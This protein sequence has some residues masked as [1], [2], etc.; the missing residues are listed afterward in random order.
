MIETELIRYGY[1]F[2]FLGTLFE[3]DATLLTAAFLAHRGYFH[4][5]WVLLI[6]GVTTFCANQVFYSIARRSGSTWL[7]NVGPHGPKMGKIIAL[8]K[9]HSGLMMI[10]SR[11]LIG[12]RTLIPAVCGVTGMRAGRF[13]LWNIAGAVIWTATFGWA[14]Y[15]GGEIFTIFFAGIRRHERDVAAAL[16]VG[17]GGLVFWMTHGRDVMDAWSLRKAL[18]KS[19]RERRLRPP[20]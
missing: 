12:F 4:F 16:A 5:S 3:G 20:D 14:G 10:A 19:A 15:L 13:I 1:L 11:F 18:A 2:V 7:K 6:A 8:S 9:K 17:V